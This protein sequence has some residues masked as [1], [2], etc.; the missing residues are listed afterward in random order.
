[1]GDIAK[2]LKNAESCKDK[3]ILDWTAILALS[4]AEIFVWFFNFDHYMEYF[5]LLNILYERYKI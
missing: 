4:L 2:F 3:Y 5:P 1:M